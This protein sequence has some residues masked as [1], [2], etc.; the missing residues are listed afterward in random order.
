[1]MQQLYEFKLDTSIYLPT[2]VE[3]SIEAE[4]LNPKSLHSL[5]LHSRSKFLNGK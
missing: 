2:L 5:T 4:K 3:V 1:M